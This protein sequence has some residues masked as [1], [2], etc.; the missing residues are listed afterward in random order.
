[1][2]IGNDFQDSPG[3]VETG[4][5]IARLKVIL[6]DL[7]ACR[8]HLKLEG[9]KKKQ[10]PVSVTSVVAH[11]RSKNWIGKQGLPQLSNLFFVLYTLFFHSLFSKSLDESQTEK[12]LSLTFL[13]LKRT[14]LI[15]R[16][17]IGHF[18]F[19]YFH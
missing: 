7:R 12:A 3:I 10:N 17:P 5:G 9:D 19:C 16:K 1:M 14:K 4:Q 6:L 18:Q 8:C 11:S 2:M 15:I 13:C